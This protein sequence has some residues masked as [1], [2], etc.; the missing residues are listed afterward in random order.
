[1]TTQ[2]N[3]Q[4]S[5]L[6][7][8]QIPWKL[9]RNPNAIING[10]IV[11][12]H[13]QLMPTNRCN[14]NCSWCSCHKVDRSVEMGI[15]ELGDIIR[16]FSKLG[17]R[18][19][20]ITGGGEPTI[21]KNFPE[22]L[23]LCR[24][25]GI[26]VGLVTNGIRWMSNPIEEDVK[27]ITWMRISATEEGLLKDPALLQIVARACPH[28]HIGVSF[29]VNGSAPLDM[30]RELCLIAEKEP[31][32]THLRFVQ[33][34]MELPAVGL[35]MFQ[36][37]LS[38]FPKAFFQWRDNFTKGIRSCLISLLKPVLNCDGQIYPCCGTQYALGFKRDELGVMPPSMSM[39]RWEDFHKQS[40][41]D[42]SVCKRCYYQ[43]YNTALKH[44]MEVMLHEDFV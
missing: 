30:A 22:I 8:G 15:D 35:R 29:T 17:T 43:D 21:H 24:L 14:G 23:Q 33:E 44:M 11:P 25:H 34:L 19:A 38:Q 36:E 32:V 1:M 37:N 18:A 2:L 6:A 26:A 27:R 9:L 40:P 28:V 7:A 31:N 41:F 13:L 20:T 16:H 4:A 12:L 42:G 39:G 3:A 5:F 10:R